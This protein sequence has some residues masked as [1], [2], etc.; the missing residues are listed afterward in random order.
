MT[1]ASTHVEA[2]RCKPWLHRHARRAP[3][4]P[5]GQPLVETTDRTIV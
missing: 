2:T 4:V 5:R 3:H 1:G